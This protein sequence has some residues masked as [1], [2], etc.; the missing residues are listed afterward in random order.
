MLRSS[1]KPVTAWVLASANCDRSRVLTSTQA[2]SCRE[3]GASGQEVP[4]PYPS[5]IPAWAAISTTWRNQSDGSTSLKVW[6]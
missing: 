3:T 1:R 4:S 5:T 2:I 6:L